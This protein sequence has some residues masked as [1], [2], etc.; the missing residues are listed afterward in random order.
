MNDLFPPTWPDSVCLSSFSFGNIFL[1]Y[2]VVAGWLPYLSAFGT[3]AQVQFWE[4]RGAWQ[5]QDG[6]LYCRADGVP[7]RSLQT[8]RRD[9][10]GEALPEDLVKGWFQCPVFKMAPRLSALPVPA[11]LCFVLASEQNLGLAGTGWGV[12]WVLS[13]VLR[14]LWPSRAGWCHLWK[15][16]KQ[17]EEKYRNKFTHFSNF[18]NFYHQNYVTR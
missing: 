9:L 2:W 4:F 15:L 1:R 11:S 10:S 6:A 7:Q 16:V 5:L 14:G 13:C 18:P 8:W 17:W 3:W 12:Q